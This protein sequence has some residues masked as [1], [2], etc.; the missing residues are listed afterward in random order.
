MPSFPKTEE[1]GC[2]KE[3]AS[4]NGDKKLYLMPGHT[5][6]SGSPGAGM[7]CK[8]PAPFMTVAGEEGE[9]LPLPYPALYR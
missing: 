8:E 9:E 5:E 3:G 2:Q 7:H 6:R 1:D 4:S